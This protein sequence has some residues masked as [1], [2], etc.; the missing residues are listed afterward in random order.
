M[1]SVFWYDEQL[2]GGSRQR[3]KLGLRANT[4]KFLTQSYRLIDTWPTLTSVGLVSCLAV[5]ILN[6]IR[7]T[8]PS[9]NSTQLK[10]RLDTIRLDW[11]TYRAR[12]F[13]SSPSMAERLL[14]ITFLLFDLHPI[15]KTENCE[16]MW[17]ELTQLMYCTQ[18][19]LYY[20]V[21]NNNSQL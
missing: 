4:P 9:N 17:R 10:R 12:F 16:V 18:S 2:L 7:Q 21:G 1:F 20:V 19:Y 11:T 6:V 13:G 15:L 14:L 8:L 3:T 5:Y